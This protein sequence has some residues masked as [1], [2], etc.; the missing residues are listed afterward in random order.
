MAIKAGNFKILVQILSDLK[1]VDALRNAKAQTIF[2]PSDEAFAELPNGF[3]Q[4]LTD[5]QKTEIVFRHLV[6]GT[7]LLAADVSTGLIKTAGGESLFLVKTPQGGVKIYYETYIEPRNVVT[8]DVKAS[9]G[10][11]HV[12]DKVIL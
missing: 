8:A 5:I 3:L 10:V 7:T 12:I 2:A 6:T 1:L 11:I 9:N 4:N